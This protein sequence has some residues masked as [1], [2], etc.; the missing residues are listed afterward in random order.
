MIIKTP[1]DWWE[2]AEETL[3]KLPE[4]ARRFMTNYDREKAE[5]LLKA[6][7]HRQ[8]HS[9]LETLWFELPE[10]PAIRIEPFNSLCDLCSEH[11]VFYERS[12]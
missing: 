3:P 10:T 7:D 5:R 11:W 9:L 4:Y 8:L 6:K 1:D 12:D 2:L